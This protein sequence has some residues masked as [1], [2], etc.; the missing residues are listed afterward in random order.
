MACGVAG[1][2]KDLGF[3]VGRAA[4]MI[5]PPGQA[6]MAFR[7]A[8]LGAKIANGEV[9]G[10]QVVDTAKA[11]GNAIVEPVTKPWNRGDRVEA[12]TRAVTEVASLFLPASKAGL[13][14]KSGKAANVADKSNEV[15]KGTRLGEATKAEGA[16]GAEAK[17]KPPAASEQANAPGKADHGPLAN[18][19]HQRSLG[20]DSATGLYRPSEAATATRLE[21]Q[22]GRRLERDQTGHADWVD[23]AGRTYDAVGP[24]PQQYFDL[25]S[26][27][28]SITGHLLKQGL[29]RVVV[30][31]T[32]MTNSQISQIKN[33]G[34]PAARAAAED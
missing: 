25:N 27:S 4:V 6:D 17:A 7:D 30:D 16:A 11:V 13:F 24:V 15:A 9:T 33:Y 12:G 3:G 20:M 18:A 10:Q 8:E 1:F 5:S 34:E 21:Q 31:T 28:K 19:L 29:D 26:F 14:G 23:S 22:L 32:G 2:V